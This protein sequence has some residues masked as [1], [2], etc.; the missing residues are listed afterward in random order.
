MDT[1]EEQA[2]KPIDKVVVLPERAGTPRARLRLR[3]GWVA[4][5]KT[6]GA[7]KVSTAEWHRQMKKTLGSMRR[8]SIQA[9]LT[10]LEI[11]VSEL[12]QKVIKLSTKVTVRTVR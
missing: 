5:G 9:R 7:A 3:D 6:D 1:E 11:L 10:Q 8:G 2:E 4:K 12:N